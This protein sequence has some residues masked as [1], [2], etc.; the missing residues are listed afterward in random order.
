MASSS[1]NPDTQTFAAPTPQPTHPVADQTVRMESITFR[2]TRI[3]NATEFRIQL[4]PST[5]FETIYHETVVEGPST[6][7]LDEALPERVERVF[8]RV[9]VDDRE[10]APWS[11]AASILVSA[12]VSDQRGDFLV[13]A[14]PVP[15]RPIQGEAVVPVGT[16]LTWERVP[17]ASGYRVQV[18]T[19]ETFED[20]I[21]NLTLDRTTYLTRYE[22]LPEGQGPLYWRVRAL[23]PNET[24]G[25]W[26]KT[27]HFHT[28]Q[29]STERDERATEGVEHSG[30][31]ATSVR[32]S[33]VAAG[34]ARHSRT[35]GGMAWAFISVL[36]VSFVLTILLIMSA[37]A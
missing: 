31:A 13:D 7:A 20:P 1:A 9:R 26:S 5:A 24:E 2:W 22:P 6:I 23:F 18:G 35:S 28:E 36:V 37:S 10:D 3:P 27:V 11:A 4:A 17:E 29:A 30:D 14:P 16:T 21:V 32:Q 34:P 19:S 12:D 15:L 33:P 8:W 25:P